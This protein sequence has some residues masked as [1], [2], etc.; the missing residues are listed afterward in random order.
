MRS[1]AQR[2]T[3]YALSTPPD[4]GGMV[5]M[6]V[7]GPE[8]LE[9]RRRMR[10]KIVH[11]DD[12]RPPRSFTMEP[13][14]ELHTHSGRA[15]LTTL[16]G[17]L[18]TLPFLRPAE[19]G[20][21][22]KCAVGGLADLIGAE[23]EEQRKIASRGAWG[24]RCKVLDGLRNRTIHCLAQDE[25]LEEG[26]Y[27]QDNRRGEIIRSGIK[28]AIFG[29]PNVGKSSLLNYLAQREAAIVT[30]IPDTT[31]DVPQ[32]ALDIGGIPVVVAD[33]T[34]LRKTEDIV[35]TIGIGK[36]IDTV[37]E[38]DIALCAV[39]IHCSDT[40]NEQAIQLPETIRK[41]AA[42]PKMYFI[43]NK[44]D[45]VDP[46]LDLDNFFPQ[47]GMP[48][49]PSSSALQS[50]MTKR[51]WMV[52]LS[53]RQGTAQFLDGFGEELCRLYSPSSQPWFRDPQAP[54]IMWTPH[55]VHLESA[56]V[57]LQAFLERP[58]KDVVLAAEELRYAARALGK[59]SG[60]IDVEDILDA[61]FRDFYI[62]K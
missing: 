32:L 40:G 23:T 34:C 54:I 19:P 21:F 47:F 50:S 51:S 61:V 58:P 42:I 52:S 22:T 12:L 45:L 43:L 48:Q 26:A 11:L 4:K 6:H 3:I 46:D 62:G 2:Q 35:E 27:D 16:L 14:L 7:S 28:L 5:A 24:E 9:V 55:H 25:D 1:D 36:G 15:L 59:V 17:A 13:P 37:K 39:S 33:T 44:A 29:P 8:A 56:C 20:E 57:F 18:S 30:A 49:P 60:A 31:C 38:V 41:L 53:E 10:C